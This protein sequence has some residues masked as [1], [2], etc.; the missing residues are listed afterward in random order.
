MF[1][2]AQEIKTFK[3]NIYTRM[4]HLH[5][6]WRKKIKIMYSEHVTIMNNIHSLNIHT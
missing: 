2:F 5:E 4:I 6:H 3:Q 1:Y